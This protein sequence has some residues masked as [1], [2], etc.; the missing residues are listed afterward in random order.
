MK[1]N[2]PY[3]LA[4]LGFFSFNSCDYIADP[5]P[6]TNTSAVD[7]TSNGQDDFTAPDLSTLKRRIL[8]EDYTGH[9]CGNCPSAA[10]TARGLKSTYGSQVY[11]MAVHA[12]FFAEPYG[13][14]SKFTTDFRTT[15]GEA[16]NTDFSVIGNPVGMVSRVEY[17]SETVLG[18][19][20]WAPAITQI[21]DKIPLFD[22]QMQL[23]YDASN[24]SISISIGT[25]IT[26][27]ITGNYNIIVCILEDSI[28]DWQKNYAPPGGDPAYP[29]ADVETYLHEHV[30]RDNINGN[31]GESIISGSEV[32]ETWII[33]NY[34][35]NLDNLWDS[36][37]CIV[38]AF[39]ADATTKEIL[40]VD[41]IHVIEEE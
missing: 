15:A 17:N 22:V 12:G 26:N 34:S 14:G 4:I 28:V 13:G 31:Y 19:G 20:A 2:L 25:Y 6:E 8:V 16:W 32:A 29:V 11:I 18:P 3:I 21:I 27:D 10:V 36:K 40:Q 7:T 39:V 1:I 5:F 9:T 41:E 33:K 30:L 35:Y 23:D 24:N 37:N 38:L